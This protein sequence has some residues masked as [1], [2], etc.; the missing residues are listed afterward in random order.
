MVEGGNSITEGEP[1]SGVG[2]VGEIISESGAQHEA[3]R[4][5]AFVDDID[6]FDAGF[7]R[8]SP[9]EAEFLDPSSG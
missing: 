2:R 6:Q 4:Y 7:F 8:I 9:V 3:C 1:G 5:G